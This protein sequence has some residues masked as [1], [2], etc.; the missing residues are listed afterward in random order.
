MGLPEIMAP[1]VDEFQ[2]LMNNMGIN[3]KLKSGD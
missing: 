1:N 3:K 2:T